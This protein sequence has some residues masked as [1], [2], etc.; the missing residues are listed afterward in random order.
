[1]EKLEY[2]INFMICQWGYIKLNSTMHGV[3]TLWVIPA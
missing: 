1:M 3:C 2:K